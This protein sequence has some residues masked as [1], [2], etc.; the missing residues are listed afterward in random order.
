MRLHR[1]STEGMPDL[2]EE[3]EE[4]EDRDELDCAPRCQQQQQQQTTACPA[5]LSAKCRVQAQEPRTDPTQSGSTPKVMERQHRLIKRAGQQMQLDGKDHYRQKGRNG[6]IQTAEK[7]E[8]S[9]HR[10]LKYDR[11]LQCGI[12]GSA[13]DASE[14]TNGHRERG[15]RISA[16]R[17]L[18]VGCLE[19]LT[20]CNSTHMEVR[21]CVRRRSEDWYDPLEPGPPLHKRPAPNYI[22]DITL[23]RP[24]TMVSGAGEEHRRYRRTQII[25]QCKH[26]D[27]T[28]AA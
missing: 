23:S 10:P 14:R 17:W 3:E 25:R 1:T 4:E 18:A 22:P 6:K 15:N 11:Q 24:R 16:H 9:S 12:V 7:K 8:S 27:Q 28:D 19:K 2:E 13:A 21:P 20:R 26:A 5:R